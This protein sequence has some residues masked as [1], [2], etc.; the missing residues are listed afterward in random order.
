M[1][2]PRADLDQRAVLDEKRDFQGAIVTPEAHA[3]PRRI[4]TPACVG[5]IE[6]CRLPA[7]MPATRQVPASD[8]DGSVTLEM[9][10]VEL[11]AR[12]LLELRSVLVESGNARGAEGLQIDVLEGLL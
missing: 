8:A 11:V 10:L 6:H 2:R 5:K 12:D 4:V 9:T 7:L 1:R 3:V